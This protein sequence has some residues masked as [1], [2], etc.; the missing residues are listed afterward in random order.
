VRHGITE[1][2]VFPVAPELVEALADLGELD[3]ARA[4]TEQLAER[5]EAQDHPWAR[6]TARRC[7][8]VIALAAGTYDEQAGAELEAAAA[9]Y[10]RLG[11]HFDAARS[12][13]AVGRTQRR[14]KQWGAARASLEQAAAAFEAIGSG[15]WAERA[16]AEL[17]RVGARRPRPTGE[18]TPTEER[19]VALAAEGLANKQIA[20]TLFVTVHT[21]EVHLSRAYQ[22][23]GVRSRSQLAA[24]LQS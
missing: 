23:L 5:A 7:A 16:Q 3:E 19:V 21:V 9:E 10:E 11:L 1:P 13:L 4:I 2:G 17:S 15:G 18:L 8:A 12:R 22:K 20:Q 14:F 6:A 24:R